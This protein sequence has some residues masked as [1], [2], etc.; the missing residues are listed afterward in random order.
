VSTKEILG[1]ALSDEDDSYISPP[2]TCLKRKENNSM[3]VEK[4]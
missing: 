3:I 2:H 1:C 4:L